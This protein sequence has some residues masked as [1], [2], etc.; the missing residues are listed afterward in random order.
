M[1]RAMCGVQVNDRK[2]AKGFMLML[3][4]YETID[5]LDMANSVHWY[6][7]VL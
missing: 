1:V 4:L 3:G 2:R 5:K 7:H 6:G